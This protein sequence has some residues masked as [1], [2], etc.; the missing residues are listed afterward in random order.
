MSEMVLVDSKYPKGEATI[1]GLLSVVF[2]ESRVIAFAEVG[3]RAKSDRFSSAATAK[4]KM[5]SAGC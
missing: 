3:A 5:I 4:L 2:C 1:A